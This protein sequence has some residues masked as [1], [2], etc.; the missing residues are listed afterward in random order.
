MNRQMKLTEMYDE[1]L[2]G[3][4]NKK[5][6]LEKMEKIIPWD[7]WLGIIKPCYYKGE[8]GNKPYDL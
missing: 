3:R 5:I 6:F 1:L 8:R 7:E 4:T 2:E